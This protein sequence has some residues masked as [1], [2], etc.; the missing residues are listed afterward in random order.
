MASHLLG[1]RVLWNGPTFKALVKPLACVLGT[2][3]AALCA[4]E[5]SRESLD[6]DI[7][8]I[9][10][11]EDREIIRFSDH[12]AAPGDGA[13]GML[14]Q[15]G[16]AASTPAAAAGPRLFGAL[17]L[18]GHGD[19]SPARPWPGE[20]APGAA[21]DCSPEA[22]PRY[23]RLNKH[24]D[25]PVLGPG[26][27][28]LERS[29]TPDFLAQRPGEDAGNEY[30]CAPGQLTAAG[31]Q[32]AVYL[33]RHLAQ[34]YGDMLAHGAAGGGKHLYVRSVDIKRSLASVVGLLMALLAAPQVLSLFGEGSEVPIHVWPNSTTST[35][36]IEELELGDHLLARWCHQM[37]W[38][39]RNSML[40][41]SRCVSVEQAASMVR[42][43]EGDFCRSLTLDAGP[44]EISLLAEMDRL[45]EE[46][47]FVLAGTDGRALTIALG[48]LLGDV[49]CDAPLTAR[50]PFSSRLVIEH[51][52][53]PATGSRWRVLWNGVDVSDKVKGCS[54]Q[55]SPGCNE[56]AVR[57]VLEQTG[58]R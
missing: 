21:W 57:A 29:F 41:G 31:F 11:E 28:R 42:R 58:Q 1:K 49:V 9:S 37:P 22:L 17:V 45:H 56:A 18:L 53:A 36:Q 7:G 14:P 47:S 54:G 27:A 24:V 10:F 13:E 2:L 15:A 50:P 23:W 33:G 44:R 5:W 26:G 48:S 25:F 3:L 52:V 34:A 32:Q 30:T 40:E 8:I 35:S 51:W 39:C 55:T 38:P 16:A 4:L 12:C 19:S 6:A 46:G 20:A 43:G